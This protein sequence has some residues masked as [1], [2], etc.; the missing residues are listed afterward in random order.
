MAGFQASAVALCSVSLYQFPTGIKS[1]S[2]HA[3]LAMTNIVTSLLGTLANGL[4]IM[5]YYRNPGLRTIQNTIF[6]L[7][8]ITDIGV[9]AFVQ[10]IFAVAILSSLLGNHIVA[11]YG[12]FKPYYRSCS[13]NYHW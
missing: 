8:A 12:D 9:T 7:L 10:P 4:V 2:L 1:M 3:A 5:A 13:R 11:F 6:F